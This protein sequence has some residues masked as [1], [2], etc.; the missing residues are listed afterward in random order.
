MRTVTPSHTHNIVFII[1]LLK[2][3]VICGSTFSSPIFI[4]NSHENGFSVVDSSFACNWV[5]FILSHPLWCRN[6][7]TITRISE[8]MLNDF[9]LRLY[10]ASCDTFFTFSVQYRIF[11]CAYAI[12]EWLI[13]NEEPLISNGE[14]VCVWNALW[15]L[16]HWMP[17][18]LNC[19]SEKFN[20]IF[21][22]ESIT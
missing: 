10:N 12:L 13:P 4:S 14:Y 3:C 20:N 11:S 22:L 2:L 21:F 16:F 15:I 1:K 9:Y 6:A 18:G 7:A 19:L 5:L 8:Q 17:Y